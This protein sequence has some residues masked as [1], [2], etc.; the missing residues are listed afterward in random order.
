MANAVNDN[1]HEPRR[2]NGADEGAYL[3][4]VGER[5]RVQRL[6]R[7]MSRKSLSQL[8]G[9]SERYLAELERG[10]GNASLLVLRSIAAALDV[11]ASELASEESDRP[12]DMQIAVEQLERLGPSQIA[13]ARQMLT[14]RFGHANIAPSGRVALIGLRGAGKTTL[15]RK[16][17]HALGIPFVEL[18]DEIERQSGMDLRELVAVRGEAVYRR[19]ERECLEHVINNHPR[20]VIAVSGGLVSDPGTYDLLLSSCYVVWL[21]TSPSQ[22]FE[23][24]RAVVPL[25]PNGLSRQALIELGKVVKEREP[26]YAKAHSKIETSELSMQ[27]LVE[28]LLDI[29]KSTGHSAV[30]GGRSGK[31]SV[32]KNGNGAH[33]YS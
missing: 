2:G 1:T 30:N 25:R 11:K 21:D 32:A 17:A 28:E 19:L 26:M 31:I 10:S 20:A 8:S 15:G 7:G 4:L 3:K 18:D 6:R 9:V 33:H 22:L 13:E 29:V 23:R 27:E 16:A 5:V 24:A 14:S 12:V